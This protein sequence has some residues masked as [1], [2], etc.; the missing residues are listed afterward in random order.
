[1]CRKSPCVADVV[2]DYDLGVTSGWLWRECEVS[3]RG[4]P[5]TFRSLVVGVAASVLTIGV[6]ATP[7]PPAA[8]AA[9]MRTA[10][11]LDA[12]G[13]ALVGRDI[14][15]PQ[16]N[17]ALPI[18]SRGAFGVL[19]TNNGISFT[20]N[21]CLVRELA[22]AKRLPLPPAF[23]ANTGNPGPLRAKHWPSGQTSPNV[24]STTD[25]NSIGCSYDYGWNAA[26][27]SYNTATDAAQRLHHVSR[28][29]ARSRAANVEWWLDIETMNS[30]QTLDGPSTRLAKQR[31]VA[32]IEGEVDALRA[33]GVES[34]GFYSTSF[35]WR[36]ITGGFA[37]TQ[38]RFAGIPV[39]LAGF[40][41]HSDA[42]AGCPHSSFTGGPVRM[43]QYLGSDGFDSDIACTGG[44]S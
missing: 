39:W 35:Q 20:R 31:D 16:C 11:V 44:S 32:T 43:T 42:V 5:F 27:Q 18:E 7:A 24:C 29:D 14:S 41:S 38:G 22:W 33:V 37:I 36:I 23:Y 6:V 28:A 17:G 8:A 40:E 3:V 4:R 9:P 1:M 21:P 19:G 15:F 2:R 12:S 30:W 13:D 26:W 10:A 34:V 25:L